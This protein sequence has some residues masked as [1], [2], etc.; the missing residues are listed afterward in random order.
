M[1]MQM[2]STIFFSAAALIALAVI[3]SMI[4]DNL[5]DVRVALG[6]AARSP[7]LPSAR[8]RVRRA[9]RGPAMRPSVAAGSPLRA[10]A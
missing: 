4:L 2:F 8:V 3:V 7:T 1:M 10:A 9:D 5:A 6:I